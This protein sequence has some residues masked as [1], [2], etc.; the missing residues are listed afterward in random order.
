MTNSPCSLSRA[1]ISLLVTPSSF[2]NSCT[3]ALPA[4]T[5]PSLEAT[6]V[7][8][9]S[10]LATTHGHR[11]FTVCSCSSLPVLLPGSSSAVTCSTAADVSGEPVM[12]NA[13]PKARRRI[14]ARR[15]CW[16]G[17]SQAPRPGRL[18]AVSTVTA[19]SPF[20]A[21]TATTRSSSTASSRL[22]HPMQVRTGPEWEAEVSRWITA[23]STSHHCVVRTAS[24][25]PVTACD[26]VT[27]LVVCQSARAAHIRAREELR[28]GRSG[29][30]RE[31]GAHPAS[32]ALH[33]RPRPAPRKRRPNL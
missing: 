23:Q 33:R 8:R 22:R 29:R 28:F 19:N 4:T 13:R 2:A 24:I 16:S 20:P 1:R 26:V 9:A 31:P 15:Q 10:G 17:C 3:R 30:E 21:G 25:S 7:G 11:G 27:A 18:P 5:S 14:A 6:A 32:T 12:R